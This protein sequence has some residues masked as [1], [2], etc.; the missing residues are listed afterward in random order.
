[1][2]RQYQTFTVVTSAVK[3]CCMLGIAVKQDPWR[4]ACLKAVD[5][6]LAVDPNGSILMHNA[7]SSVQL[8]ASWEV[9]NSH[10]LWP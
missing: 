2:L 10:P 6:Q 8:I 5:N 7:M 3:A 9:C 1:M 4:N